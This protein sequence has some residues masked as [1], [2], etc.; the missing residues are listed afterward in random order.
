MPIRGRTGHGAAMTTIHRVE[1]L[2]AW[3]AATILIIIAYSYAMRH[4]NK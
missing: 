4:I 2:A 1:I 3:F